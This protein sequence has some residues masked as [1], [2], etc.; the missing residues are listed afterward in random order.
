M[1]RA[2]GDASRARKCVFEAAGM[3]FDVVAIQ[4]EPNPTAPKSAASTKVWKTVFKS[5]I[6]HRSVRSVVWSIRL[7]Q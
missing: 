2:A 1:G 3:M 5:W 7:T 4:L 6:K